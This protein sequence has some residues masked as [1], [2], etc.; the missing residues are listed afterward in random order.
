MRLPSRF[1]RHKKESK[2]QAPRLAADGALPSWVGAALAENPER[3]GHQ[4]SGGSHLPEQPEVENLGPTRP[5]TQLLSV[6]QAAHILSVSQKTVQRLL[7]RGAVSCVR[8][9]RSIRIH[10]SVIETLMQ[11]GTGAADPKPADIKRIRHSRHPRTRQIT[12]DLGN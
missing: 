10:S 4:W 6:K 7:A 12:G 11:T 5:D 8:I 3:G 1:D 2:G 9:G